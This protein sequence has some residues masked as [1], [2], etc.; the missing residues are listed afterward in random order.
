LDIEGRGED[1]ERRTSVGYAAEAEY[2]V[3]AL[4]DLL[5]DPFGAT[6]WSYAPTSISASY[7]IQQSKGSSGA[8]DETT[9]LGVAA[10]WDWDG[11]YAGLGYSYSFQDDQQVGSGD[12]D[13]R[14]EGFDIGGGLYGPT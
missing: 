7:G 1:R 8:R 14:S 12:N 11:G 3:Q 6:F 5:G 2:E 13:Y 4:R 10:S 9:E